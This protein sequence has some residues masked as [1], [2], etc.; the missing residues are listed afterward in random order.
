MKQITIALMLVKHVFLI[1]FLLI[2]FPH[3]LFASPQI[4]GGDQTPKEKS[5]LQNNFFRSDSIYNPARA[6]WVAAS[7]S[8]TYVASMGGLYVLWYRDY[9]SSSFHLFNDADEWLQ[10]DKLGHVT[11]AYYLSRWSND[12]FKWSGVDKKKAAL[13]A[14]ATGFTYQTT[15]EIFDG[16]S[17]QWGFSLADLSA[18]ALGSSL[19]LSQQLLWDEQ[20]IQFKLSFHQSKFAKYRPSLLGDGLI[21]NL[22]KDYNG[23]T[24]WLSTNVHSWLNPD[25]KFPKWLNVAI[26]YG[27][28][29]MIGASANPE[30]INGINKPF[31]DRYRQFYIAPDIDLTKIKTQS[32]FLNTLFKTF[33][34]I[35]FPTSALEINSNGKIILKPFYF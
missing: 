15:I 18:N 2:A 24:Y 12:L 31:F 27:A 20:R 10:M 28:E 33:G 9:P 16:F 3:L 21:E 6:K 1:G 25:S 11:S 19:F 4:S 17:S 22:F 26:G 35:K 34:F 8:S 30:S 23:Q 7:L 32:G 13:L 5:K 29:G 14:A